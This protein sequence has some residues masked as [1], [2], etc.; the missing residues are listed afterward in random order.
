MAWT[1]EPGSWRE[2]TRSTNSTGDQTRRVVVRR[3]SAG[4]ASEASGT[5]D[6]RDARRRPPSD[7]RSTTV[8]V[9]RRPVCPH[10][11]R[12]PGN[13]A[14]CKRC[15]HSLADLKRLPTRREWERDHLR[16][17]PAWKSAPDRQAEQEF[18]EFYDEHPVVG[19]ALDVAMSSTVAGFIRADEEVRAG[20]D[21]RIDGHR[22]V[23]VITDQRFLIMHKK[24]LSCE[25][26]VDR[27]I[28]D[29]R[30]V[31]VEAERKWLSSVLWLGEGDQRMGVGFDGRDTAE[32]LRRAIG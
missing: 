4:G 22:A 8:G 14:F 25:V 16:S 10:C 32:T 13:G 9:G 15:G 23:I 27:P 26:I 18:R 31:R 21:T 3:E 1:G 28:T 6:G 12:R 7:P 17:A 2:P 5:A 20:A 11:G 24:L 29:L 30:N 19:R